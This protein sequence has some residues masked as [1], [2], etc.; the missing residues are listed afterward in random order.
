MGPLFFP[1]LL[2]T[3]RGSHWDKEEHHNNDRNCDPVY[4]ENLIPGSNGKYPGDQADHCARSG[5]GGIE[6]AHDGS[7][8]VLIHI[9]FS[10]KRHGGGIDKSHRDT[11]QDTHGEYIIDI[12]HSS[13]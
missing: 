12:L 7:A 1:C 6:D 3:F 8:F 11:Y 13:A 4:L 9:D 10:N 2:V 5:H